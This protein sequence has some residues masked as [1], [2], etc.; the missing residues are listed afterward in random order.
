MALRENGLWW[1][2]FCMTLNDKQG[3]RN[4]T[5]K[6]A[7]GRGARPAIDWDTA[8][9]YYEGLSPADR[10][11]AAVAAKFDV[12]VR[13]VETHGRKE[14][15]KQRVH[16]IRAETWAQAADSLV[17]ARVGEI[18]EMRRRV[19]CSCA[20]RYKRSSDAHS[21]RRYNYA[22]STS[23]AQKRPANA[24]LMGGTGLE[25]V[26]PS[27]SERSRALA[28]RSV[29]IRT[30]T[31]TTFARV[32]TADG[33]VVCQRCEIPGS[34]F[35]R[36]RGLLGRSGLEPGGGMLIDRAGSVHM[37]FMRFPIDVVFLDRDRKVVGVRHRLAPWRVAGARRAVAALELPAGTAVAAGIREGDM[38]LLENL[39]A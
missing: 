26:T 17:M 8:F 20:Q 22:A 3:H 39:D 4:W 21:K 33:A 28:A 32:R 25:P 10:S 12:S 15:W 13:T 7:R 38:L 2:C 19:H 23:S 36:A 35:G 6:G 37:F 1:Q 14:K 27:L 5:E 18:E 29:T 31:A 34:A 11:Y 24:G 16:A 9:V 30:V